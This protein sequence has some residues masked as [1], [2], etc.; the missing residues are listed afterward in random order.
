MHGELYLRT[1]EGAKAKG[2]LIW[3]CRLQRR[4]DCADVSTSAASGMLNRFLGRGFAA[5]GIEGS[6]IAGKLGKCVSVK[7]FD[8]SRDIDQVRL[9]TA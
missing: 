2:R 8:R 6:G 1:E 5:A 4:A 9:S 3:V 7:F